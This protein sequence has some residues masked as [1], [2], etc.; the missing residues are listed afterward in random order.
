MYTDI[1]RRE[2]VMA[3]GCTE[4]AAVALCCAAGAALLP[5]DAEKISIGVSAYIYKNGM[6]VGIPGGRGLT[7]L[8]IA[9]ALGACVKDPSRGL[10]IF[11]GATDR[12]A[13]R[14]EG[15]VSGGRVDV[16][17]IKSDEKI[18]IEALI[19]GG[20]HTARSVTLRYHDHIAV[21][22][23]DGAVLKCEMPVSE[24]VPL[25]RRMTVRGIYEYC[26]DVDISSLAVLSEVETV[27]L[28]IANEGLRGEW[29][30]RV[31]K[32]LRAPVFSSD[33]TRWA[34]S[35]TAAAADARMAGCE[36]PVMSTAGSGNQGLTA[37]LPII[38][39]AKHL[40]VSE[41]KMLRALALSELI[42]IHTKAYIGRLSVLCGCG[43]SSATGVCAGLVQMMD[44][45]YDAITAGIRTMAA[46]ITG[47]VCD[48]AKPGCAIKIAT[49]VQAAFQAASLAL[50]GTGANERDGI[51]D[52]D[53]EKTLMNLGH[54]GNEGMLGANDAILSM[55]MKS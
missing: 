29:G 49:C 15:M 44:G 48:G 46:D 38:A 51:I 12:L 9:S 28:R 3:L 1:L 20:G 30:L 55:I 18:H 45:D 50:S 40:G 32:C 52:K 33:V 42:T 27:N 25:D 41:E 36:L 23:L 10:Q 34:V 43:I 26:R 53:I 14:A 39:A 6:N 54:L 24:E 2:V 21:M 31:G 11:A 16:H 22:E 17:I 4:P 7:G 47:M 37:S 19:E 5:A 35:L 13:A 8:S